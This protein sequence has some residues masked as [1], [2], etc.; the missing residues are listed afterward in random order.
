MSREILDQVDDDLR[1]IHEEGPSV[2]PHLAKKIE[3]AFFEI[4]G[5]NNAKL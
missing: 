5:D 4:S 3:N 2:N 1:I